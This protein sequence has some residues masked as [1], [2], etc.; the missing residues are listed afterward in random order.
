VCA[1]TQQRAAVLL[2]QQPARQLVSGGTLVRT[3]SRSSLGAVAAPASVSQQAAIAPQQARALALEAASVAA[4]AAA[5][6]AAACAA[7]AAAAAA[8]T[9]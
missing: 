3:S 4:A 6:C 8:A 2:L 5:A 7:A 9:I 1:R